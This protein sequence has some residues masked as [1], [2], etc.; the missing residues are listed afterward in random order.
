M[1][2]AVMPA[3]AMAVTP[4]AA[5]A[6]PAILCTAGNPAGSAILSQ[7][8]TAVNDYYT[9]TPASPPNSPPNSTL[10]SAV[11]VAIVSP[12]KKAI[13]TCGT[14]AVGGGPAVDSKTLYEIGSE[15]KMFTA[16]ALAQMVLR[17]QVGLDDPLRNLIPQQYP[18]PD[19]TCQNPNPKPITLRMLATH[20][21]GL[22]SDPK[23]ITWND[24][25]PQLRSDYT[26]TNLFES[27]KV[28]YAKPCNAL[29]STPGTKYFYS[30]WGF[31]LL[32]A[33]L[34]DKYRP[35][36]AIPP[37]GPMVGDLVTGPLG[38]VSTILEPS[39]LPL[40]SATP[41][42]ILPIVTPCQW[43]NTNAFAGGGGMVSNIEDMATFVGAN[44]G[45][46]REAGVYPALQMTQ[47]P[48]GFGPQCPS[49]PNC[50][51]LAWDL[52]PIG[53][54]DNPSQYFVTL[55]KDGG[56]NGFHS[57]TFIQPAAC[58]GSTFLSNSST[59]VGVNLTGFAGAIIRALQPTSSKSL[60]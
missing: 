7:V 50:E 53:S 33:A 17:K 37:F 45:F 3:L 41:T 29:M 34:A 14:T 16:T 25:K 1:A 12:G 38:M 36:Q 21:A 58:W 8:T 6:P 20:N 39:V 22:P 23:N 59:N 18:L 42:C 10:L 60:C 31:A 52:A 47:R 30:D 28:G 9:K 27:F 49:N 19:N 35:G 24:K 46:Q 54:G 43:N 2:L 15:T 55:N 32:G 56:T 57:N 44:L 4:H 13:V 26:R 5:A 48:W 51:G 40:N 11:A